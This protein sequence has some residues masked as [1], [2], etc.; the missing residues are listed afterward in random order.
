MKY[1]DIFVYH[2]TT[3]LMPSLLVKTFLNRWTFG[4]F[5]GKEFGWLKPFV[6]L[7]W[8]CWKMKNSL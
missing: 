4:E 8:S 3:N 5:A 6:R 2:F 1:D 7:E